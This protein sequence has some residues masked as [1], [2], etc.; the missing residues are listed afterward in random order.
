MKDPH[1][2]REKRKYAHPIASREAILAC[3]ETI[4]EPVAFKRLAKTLE[5]DEGRDRDA[6]KLRLRA[7]VRDGQLLVDRRNVYAVA[8][9]LEMFPGVISAHPDGFGF[10]VCEA[11]RD[12]IF[13][14][15]RQMRAVFHGDKVLVR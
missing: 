3:M 9:K 15:H 14:S 11:E 4:G 7:M 10:V 1:Y 12:D 2:R 8:T 5:I 6:L 13:L